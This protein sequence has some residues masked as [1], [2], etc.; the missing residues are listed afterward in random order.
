[1]E[2]LEKRES[3]KR[4]DRGIVSIREILLADGAP[5]L[6]LKDIVLMRRRPPGL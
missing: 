5:V 3:R 4:P 2:F 6:S 1:M